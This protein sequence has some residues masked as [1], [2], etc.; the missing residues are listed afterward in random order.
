M[1]RSVPH[2]KLDYYLLTRLG[3]DRDNSSVGSEGHCIRK[4]IVDLLIVRHIIITVKIFLVEIIHGS[5]F[6]RRM[7][8]TRRATRKNLIACI[9]KPHGVRNEY[10]YNPRRVKAS[11]AELVGMSFGCIFL[12]PYV[13]VAA[14]LDN[15][16]AEFIP[17]Q[18]SPENA[19]LTNKEVKVLIK[20]E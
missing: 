2:K 15:Y 18:W 10:F 14:K 7:I 11:V 5:T 19:K 4:N 17:G 6:Y 8:K 9:R 13:K 12:R 1:L 20:G 3:V 16:D